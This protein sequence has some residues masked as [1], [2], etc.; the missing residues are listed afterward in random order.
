MPLWKLLDVEELE[1]IFQDYIL[2]YESSQRHFIKERHYQRKRELFRVLED[3]WGTSQ[4]VPSWADSHVFMH[5]NTTAGLDDLDR[6]EVFE[7]F[8]MEKSE[9]MKEEKRKLERREGRKKREAFIHLLDSLKDRIIPSDGEAMRWDDLQ[10]LIK[11]HHAYF[12]LIGSRN[13]SQPY[14]LFTELRSKW[15]HER[16][17]RKRSLS[18]DSAVDSDA[19]RPR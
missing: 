10:P 16:E 19:K 4:L 12:D 1:D 14:D 18:E 5:Q 6:F 2:S 11:D 7:D 15:K 13:S 3:R 8:I 9:K 17:S